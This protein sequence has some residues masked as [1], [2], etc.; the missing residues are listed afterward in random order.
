M[1]KLVAMVSVYNAGEFIENR[2]DN[3]SRSTM[4][5]DTEI[6]VV[7]ANSPDP[8]DHDIPSKFQSNNLKYV[9]LPERV[10]V[11][12]AWNHIIKHSESPYLTNANA[13]DLIAPNGYEKM[14]RT[15]ELIPNSAF[16]YPSWYTTSIPNLTWDEV[17]RGK[18]TDKQGKPGN[19]NGD[20]GTG[21]VG[22][23]PLWKRELHAKLGYFDEEFKALGDADWWARC[24]WVG[25]ADFR[26]HKEYLACYLWRNGPNPEDRNLWDKEINESE[27]HKY[28]TKV[29]VYKDGR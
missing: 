22:H 11:Y 12:A 25:N 7:N 1:K 26:W 6:W 17:R 24:R 4:A 27:W 13:D 15:L 14:I 28:H 20:L 10:G 23:F 19:Y 9:R 5:K 18:A 21:G 8:R 29:Q 16:A 3:L 2:L